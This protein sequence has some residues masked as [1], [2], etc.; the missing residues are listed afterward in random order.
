MVVLLPIVHGTVHKR[1]PRQAE[2]S[3]RLTVEEVEQACQKHGQLRNRPSQSTPSLEER[4]G[5]VL[6]LILLHTNDSQEPILALRNPVGHQMS[7]I[8][9]LIS[10]DQCKGQT[11]YDDPKVQPHAGAPAID[12][13][14]RSHELRA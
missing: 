11:Q 1:Q 10:Q 5:R 6:R 8:E 14:N 9:S 3:E 12:A 2:K 7:G 13:D 4:V